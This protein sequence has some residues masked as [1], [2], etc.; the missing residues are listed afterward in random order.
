M[1]RI[2]AKVWYSLLPMVTET[3][4]SPPKP[5]E[6]DVPHYLSLGPQGPYFITR[7]SSSTPLPAS[8]PWI[9]GPD[10]NC[11]DHQRAAYV[12]PLIVRHVV[13]KPPLTF[14][15]YVSSTRIVSTS[16]VGENYGGMSVQRGFSPLLLFPADVQYNPR[17]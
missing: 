7:Q 10:T 16:D 12:A 17:R 2:T 14:S 8:E 15:N 3:H 13:G 11:H 5:I 4:V 9:Q 1:E 6:I